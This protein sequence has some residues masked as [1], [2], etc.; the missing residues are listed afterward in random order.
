MNNKLIAAIAVAIG[1]STAASRADF[2]INLDAGQ[3]VTD[4][5]TT[6]ISNALLLIVQAGA[7]GTFSD[8]AVGQY[9]SG[10]DTVLGSAAFNTNIGL[11]E[12]GNS[13]SITI[14]SV[15]GQVLALRWFADITFAQYI[16][17]TLTEAGDK[18]GTYS[19]LGTPDGG[20]LWVV[21]ASGTITLNFFTTNSE[22]G[23]TQAP[24]A[25]Y[26]SST[27][28]A[29]PEPTTL[30][31]GALGAGAFFFLRRRRD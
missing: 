12:T 27:V 1:I 18:Y 26:A 21:P 22:F 9:V 24:S 4:P 8:L 10:D 23:G 13:I 11:N 17:G 7:D 25:G 5:S 6:L 29:I 16:G 20:N 30:A 28:T 19:A 31:L 14:P 15:V 3:L 2:T